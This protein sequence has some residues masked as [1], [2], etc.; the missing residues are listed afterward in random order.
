MLF[1]Y[2]CISFHCMNIH[3]DL[4]IPLLFAVTS[5]SSGN[6]VCAHFCACLS[7]GYI[8][9][10]RITRLGGICI[11]NFNRYH[12]WTFDKHY[13]HTPLTLNEKS[14]S[15][16]L[17]NS[18]LVRLGNLLTWYVKTTTTTTKRHFGAV[19]ILFFLWMRFTYFYM[20]KSHS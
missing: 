9:K 11:C 16:H 20:F 7:I 14:I 6:L 8:L 2:S 3:I 17:T 5:N 4:T 10:N 19:L 18:V 1:F 12:Q 15:P 13:A